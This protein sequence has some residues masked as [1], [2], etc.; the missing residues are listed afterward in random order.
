M[1]RSNRL[2]LFLALGVDNDGAI[3]DRR[4]RIGVIVA[5]DL[6]VVDNHVG[7]QIDDLDA[8]LVD[9]AAAIDRAIDGEELGEATGLGIGVAVT[10]FSGALF[11]AT[12]VRSVARLAPRRRVRF[13]ARVG[14]SRR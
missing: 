10:A 11:C 5:A 1:E 12:F 6:V 7:R 8:E 4:R 3:G 2:G 9:P 14:V 13:P